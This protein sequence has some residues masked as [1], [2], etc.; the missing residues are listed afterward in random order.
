ML[1]FII[2]SVLLDLEFLRVDQYALFQLVDRNRE[3]RAHKIF[4]A[5]QRSVLVFIVTKALVSKLDPASDEIFLYSRM[6]FEHLTLV[7]DILTSLA[8]SKLEQ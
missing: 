7:E 3:E 5:T 1:L 4:G 2:V 8:K 6:K